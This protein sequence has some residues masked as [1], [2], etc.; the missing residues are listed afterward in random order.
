MLLIALL[1][2]ALPVKRATEQIARDDIAPVQ[3][4]RFECDS[5]VRGVMGTRDG[6]KARAG[7]AARVSQHQK[8]AQ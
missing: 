6:E 1:V 5:D 7:A 3:Q 2:S 4:D 8:A